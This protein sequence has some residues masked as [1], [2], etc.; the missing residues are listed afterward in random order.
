MRIAMK[1]KIGCKG[2]IGFDAKRD[3][4]GHFNP[5]GNSLSSLMTGIRIALS[6][7]R[8]RVNNRCEL[9]SATCE[10]TRNSVLF[11]HTRRA[12]KDDVAK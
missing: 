11:D 1:K 6:L 5:D 3:Y 10:E 9:F 8:L 4:R 7:L 12:R 2:T